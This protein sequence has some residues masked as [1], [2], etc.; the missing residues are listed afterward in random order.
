MRKRG[1][2]PPLLLRKMKTVSRVRHKEKGWSVWVLM[3]EQGSGMKGLGRS[4]GRA[5]WRCRVEMQQF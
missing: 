4:E 5:R 1:L 3:G 2:V